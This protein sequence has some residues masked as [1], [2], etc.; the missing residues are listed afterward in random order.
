MITVNDR[1]MIV[2]IMI[3]CL[4]NIAIRQVVKITRIFNKSLE[5]TRFFEK[6][7]HLVHRYKPHEARF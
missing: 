5:D 7:S 2:K 3:I 6:K 4:G 1:K